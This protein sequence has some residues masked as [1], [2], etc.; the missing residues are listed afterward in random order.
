MHLFREYWPVARIAQVVSSMGI[1]PLTRFSL[2]YPLVYR[3]VLHH[4][5]RRDTY[6]S[7]KA[8]VLGLGV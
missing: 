7:T 1:G 3:I 8:Q 5:S 6:G 2:W 4:V